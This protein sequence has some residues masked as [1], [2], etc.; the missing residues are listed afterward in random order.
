[1]QLAEREKYYLNFIP[2]TH[3]HGKDTDI[4]NCL[5]G[6]GRISY[7]K[8]TII[9]I[10]PTYYDIMPCKWEIQSQHFSGKCLCLQYV[11]SIYSHLMKI[12]GKGKQGDLNSIFV[13]DKKNKTWHVKY[14]MLRVI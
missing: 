14:I 13:P 9:S 11:L 6:T 7:L 4:V 8:F 2:S 12:G 5:P 3:Y 1:M 10:I